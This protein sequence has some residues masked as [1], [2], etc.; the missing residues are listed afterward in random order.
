[1]PGLITKPV[2]TDTMSDLKISLRFFF[3]NGYRVNVTSAH[4]VWR[5]QDQLDTYFELFAVHPK[6]VDVD[7]WPVE[8]W[9][10][11]RW[12]PPHGVGDLGL[13]S[14]LLMIAALPVPRK[15]VLEEE[16]QS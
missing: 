15:M 9:D 13:V 16:A 8:H 1:M 10:D 3:P 2:V 14:K 11:L 6:V 5:R 4:D 12:G 7:G